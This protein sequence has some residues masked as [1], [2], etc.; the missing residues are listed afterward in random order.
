[1]GSPLA[2][3]PSLQNLGAQCQHL[4]SC[5]T[6]SPEP[7]LQSVCRANLLETL[8]KRSP[9]PRSSGSDPWQEAEESFPAR[10]AASRLFIALS[11][12]A[13]RGMRD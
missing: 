3:P 12:L 6:P 9:S 13:P 10:A 1:M 2:D 5:I 8:P 11:T 4:G 7:S